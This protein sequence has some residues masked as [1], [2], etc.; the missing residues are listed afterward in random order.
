MDA[1]T[2]FDGVEVPKHYYNAVLSTIRIVADD[3]TEPVTLAEAKTYLLVTYTDRDTELTALISRC[4]KAL[5]DHK[6]ISIVTNTITAILNN[7]V[8]GMQIPYGPVTAVSEIKDLDDNILTSDQYELKDYS[9]T[10]PKYNF[11]TV[12]YT[13]GYS[14]ENPMPLTIKQELLELIAWVFFNKGTVAEGLRRISA[15]HSR[16]SWLV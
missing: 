13:A 15:F 16:K 12:T 1:L 2:N 8:G 6:E 11:L 4:R 5:E 14:E 9:I 3:V 10:Y 7:S